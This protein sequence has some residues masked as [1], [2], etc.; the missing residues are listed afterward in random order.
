MFDSFQIID[1]MKLHGITKLYEKK[2]K[3]KGNNYKDTQT[4]AKHDTSSH[5]AV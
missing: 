1:D 2:I 3:S 5:H 4:R